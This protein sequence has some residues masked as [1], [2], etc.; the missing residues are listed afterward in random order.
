MPEQL[1]RGVLVGHL[2]RIRE[3]AVALH[4]RAFEHWV[5]FTDR[6]A[7]EHV[8]EGGSHP[9][10]TPTPASHGHGP[11]VVTGDLGRS[12][13]ATAIEH[14]GDVLRA[15]V[16]PA[17]VPHR[18]KSAGRRRGAHSSTPS[19]GQIGEYVEHMG[20]PFM[21]PTAKDAEHEALRFWAEE[22]GALGHR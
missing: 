16:G 19:A 11:A 4:R 7:N 17:D 20:F 12:V 5:A 1:G 22:F 6:K 18:R 9:P 15:R 10:G 14:A 13:R 8:R 3:E 2:T 21:A